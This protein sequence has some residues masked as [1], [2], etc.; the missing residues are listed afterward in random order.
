MSSSIVAKG[1]IAITR[2]H[3]VRSLSIVFEKSLFTI[4]DIAGTQYVALIR[5]GE[6]RTVENIEKYIIFLKTFISIMNI[7][8]DMSQSRYYTFLGEFKYNYRKKRLRYEP[9]VDLMKKITIRVSTRTVQISSGELVKKLKKS[10]SGYTPELIVETFE[11]I[12]KM[13]TGIIN[14]TKQ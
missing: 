10:R 1:L 9:Y 13:M 5:Q 12:L 2:D 7:A 14:E 11:D 6:S 4:Q 8:A 3:G